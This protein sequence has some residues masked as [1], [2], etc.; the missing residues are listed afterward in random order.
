MERQNHFAPRLRENDARS[1]P[2]VNVGLRKRQ[3]GQG[4]LWLRGSP[5]GTP[6]R[7]DPDAGFELPRDIYWLSGYDGQ[8]IQ[9]A[10]IPSQQL[11]VMRLGITPSELGF[12]L[13]PLLMAA[14]KATQP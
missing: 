12:K 13:Q 4:Q 1:G 3:Y 14:V 6:V 2:R 11:A 8:A 7:Q 10:A 5:S 9:I